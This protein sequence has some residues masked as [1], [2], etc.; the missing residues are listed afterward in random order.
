MILLAYFLLSHRAQS[1]QSKRQ[2]VQGAP[3]WYTSHLTFLRLQ[4]RQAIL[5]R[6]LPGRLGPSI[7]L[8]CDSTLSVGE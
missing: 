1:M 5:A 4:L 8:G 7:V 2:L 6:F 3:L